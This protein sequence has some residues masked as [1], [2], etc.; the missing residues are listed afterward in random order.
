MKIE[1]L[2]LSV[3][4]YN[5]LK[6]AKI[7]TVEQVQQMS[8]EDLMCVRN[9]GAHTLAELMEKVA[10][11]KA[12]PTIDLQDDFF[13]TVLNCAVRYAI[14]RKT[15]MP[16]LVIGFITPLIPHLSDKTLWCFDQDVTNARWEGGYG[17]P[18]DERDWKKFLEAVRVERTKRGETPYKSH[19]EV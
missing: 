11:V 7:D 16:G 2:N 9:M 12:K 14:G 1:E 13:G 19:W 17:D 10:N 3:R 4:A 6:R 8:K 15:Y 18:C 5:V